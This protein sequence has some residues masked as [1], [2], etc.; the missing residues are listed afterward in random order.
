MSNRDWKA[1]L[2]QWGPLFASATL[3]TASPEIAKGKRAVINDWITNDRS[4]WDAIEPKYKTMLLD[5]AK[6]MGRLD[7]MTPEWFINAV[8]QDLPVIAS[9]FLGDEQASAWLDREV[10]KIRQELWGQPPS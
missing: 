3:K 8:R 10:A 6:R 2:G 7:W 4:L 5:T 9:L 1:L